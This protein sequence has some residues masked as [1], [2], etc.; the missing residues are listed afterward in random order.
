MA[1]LTGDCLINKDPI[2]SGGADIQSKR[3]QGYGLESPGRTSCQGT[4]G[5]A[6]RRLDLHAIGLTLKFVDSLTANF[7]WGSEPR[8]GWYARVFPWLATLWDEERVDT[9]PG[10]SGLPG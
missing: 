7:M 3:V 5:V 8:W 1:K 4:G 2:A 10:E 9:L 6:V